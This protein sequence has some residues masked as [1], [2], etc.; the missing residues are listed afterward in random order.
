MPVEF[1]L[2]DAGV[3]RMVGADTLTDSLGRTASVVGRY[4]VAS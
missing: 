3:G 1:G 4:L 2:A